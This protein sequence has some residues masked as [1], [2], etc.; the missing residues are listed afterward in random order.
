MDLTLEQ[1]AQTPCAIIL[2]QLGKRALFMLGAKDLVAINDR[3]GLRFKI[4]RNSKGVNRVEIVLAD[5]DTYT[6]TFSSVRKPRGSYIS[7]VKV[8]TEC[9]MVYAE[10]LHAT[11]EVHTGLYTSL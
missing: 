4:G 10:S 5:N 2:D 7:D 11:I 8:L 1:A 6:V 3:K 9:E